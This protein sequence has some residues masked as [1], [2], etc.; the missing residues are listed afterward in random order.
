MI[1][2]NIERGGFV[3]SKDM[4][5]SLI[6]DLMANGFQRIYPTLL[7]P[8]TFFAPVKVLLEATGAVDPLNDASVTDKQPWRIMFD[9]Q[10]AERCFMYVGT[11][12]TLPNDGS[13]SYQSERFT[14][15]N[16]MGSTEILRISDVIGNI[17]E[18]L[19]VTAKYMSFDGPA[20]GG[21]YLLADGTWIP[22]NGDLS[23]AHIDEPQYGFVNRFYKAETGTD[24]K[25][26]PNR[27][28]VVV[29]DRGVWFGT[30]EEGETAFN[31]YNFNW[32]LIQRPVDSKTGEVLTT[33]KAPV[34]CVAYKGPT[35]EAPSTGYMFQ[36]VVREADILKP[37]NGYDSRRRAD[38][39]APDSNAI[40][41]MEKQVSISEG[42][43]N[44][45]T[46]PGRLTTDRYYYNC[47]LDMIGF[48][49][50]DVVSQD[51]IVPASVY[52]ESEIR[53]YRAMHSTLP[54]NTGMRI[55]VIDSEPEE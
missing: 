47:E 44:L 27:Y 3:G 18:K 33:G 36:T 7:T 54:Y 12:T 43:D 45:M 28:R 11:P 48:M 24:F 9:Y 26:Y 5:W 1:L 6:S 29:T 40:I 51:W 53:T 42:Q 38:I 16:I 15:Y 41:N 13:L 50:A 8:A 25:G 31:A 35:L 39:D 30:W 19:G 2:F 49:S 55:L 17:H 23:I 32:V 46:F 14:T 21:P 4:L 34:W 20:Q 52:G 10:D 37:S 22:K